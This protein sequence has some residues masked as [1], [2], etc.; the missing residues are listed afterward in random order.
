LKVTIL[1]N[2]YFKNIQVNKMSI[3]VTGSSGF[4]GSRTIMNLSRLG[5]KVCGIDNRISNSLKS[6]TN[7]NIKLL[8]VDIT[9][10]DNLK[11]VL[12]DYV[13]KHGN[14]DYVIHYAAYWNYENSCLN[15][16]LLNNVEGTENIY[17]I[18]SEYGVNKF[19]FASSVEALPFVI[20][21]D[22]LL[23]EVNIYKNIHKY[24]NKI[25]PHPYGFSKAMSEKFLIDKSINKNNPGI[26]ILRLGGVFSDWC[27]LPPLSWLINRWSKNNILGRLIPGKG[28]TQLPF[29]HRD[30]L[31]L[32]LTHIIANKECLKDDWNIFMVSDNNILSHEEL[33]KTIRRSLQLNDEGI[34][35]DKD[36]IKIGLLM[37]K[38]IGLKP[39]EQM[40]ML[41][42]IDKRCVDDINLYKTDK[43]LKWKQDSKLSLEVKL[44]EM[45]NL[46]KMEIDQW[47]KKQYEREMHKYEYSE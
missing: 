8:T 47:N 43:L 37:E 4:L 10:R 12:H 14:I 27:E 34:K 11:Y 2:E 46:F 19:I 36:I 31:I 3:L 1:D 32:L 26:I 42:L 25:K 22:D 23:G 5:Y 16:Y 24:D 41:D 7:N 21:T 9:N 40:W 13:K 6:I 30:N 28:M 44:P 17:N 39:P 18:T 15:E 45:I 20:Q 33:F 29:I 38:L 35:I